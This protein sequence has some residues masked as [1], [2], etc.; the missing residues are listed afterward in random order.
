MGAVVNDRVEASLRRGVI[1]T[2]RKMSAGG[3]SPAQSGNVSTRF[4]DGMLITPTGMPYDALTSDDIVFVDADGSSPPS[5]R[6]PSS[7][8][9][10]HAA[11]YR[12]KPDAHAIVHCHSPHATALACARKPIP[13]FHYMVA[14]AGGRDIPLAAYA[15]F[16]TTELAAAIVETLKRRRACLLAN[17]GQVAVGNTLEAALDLAR[18]VEALAAQYITVLQLGAVHILDDAE[19]DRVLAKFETYGQQPVLPRPKQSLRRPKRT[20]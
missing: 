5:S 11:I 14:V 13:A 9:H 2:A 17:H 6:A 19:M 16:G 7:E 4:N 20:V 10:F 8:W 15:T 18:E 12:E 3:L 1:E